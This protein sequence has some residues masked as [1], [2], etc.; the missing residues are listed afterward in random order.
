MMGALPVWVLPLQ[1]E[2][3]AQPTEGASARAAPSGAARHLPLKR[4]RR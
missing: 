3:A 4:G 2:V 1:G